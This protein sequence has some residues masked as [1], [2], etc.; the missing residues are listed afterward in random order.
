MFAKSDIRKITIA[1]EKSFYSEVYL[2]LGK[3]GIVHLSRFHERDSVADTGLQH[4]E[5]RT[6][7]ILSG[8]EYA[9]NA[10][11][12]EPE[13]ADVSAQIFD[14]SRDAA[15]VSETKKTIERVVRL[16]KRIR[17]ESDAIAEQVEYMDA[18]NRMGIEPAM[19]E[20][21]RLVNTVFGTVDKTAWDAASSERFMI[22]G[23]G[24]YVFGIALPADFPGMIQF[25]KNYGLIDKSHDVR[26]VS[27]EYLKKR[28]DVLERRI[29]ILDGY[30]HR[31]KEE[32]EQALKRLHSA[33]LAYEKML[34]AMRMSIFSFRAMFVS[35]WMDIKD[36][37][38]LVGI[39]Q[40]ICGNRFVFSERKDPDAPVRL[41]N[42]RLLKPF[43]LLVKTMGMPSNNEIDPTP[44][45]AVTF[46]VMFGLMFG[47]LGQGSVL[48]IGG[49]ILRKFGKKRLRDELAQAGG[50][51]IACGCSAALCGILYGSIFS[52]EHIIPALWFHPAAHIM[53]MFS[54]AVLIG[55]VFIMA[56]LCVNIINSFLNADYT[57]ALL[58]KR[59]LAVLVLYAAVVFLTICYQRT[60]QL[61][62]PWE[63]SVFIILPLMLFSLKGVLGSALFKKAKPQSIS[64]YIIETFLEI[65]EIA[66]S[67]FANTISFIRM[68]AFALSHAGLSIATYTLAGMADPG[69]KSAG[70][71]SIIVI[72]N[73][74]I[75][76]LEGLICVIQS[77][78]LEYYEFFSKFFK[79]NGVVFTPFTLKA[80]ATEV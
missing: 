58:E 62:T 78:R 52:S 2:A 20:Q 70:A 74:F 32:S 19:I 75:I 64:K 56:G 57:E 34:T 37:E 51:L 8:V 49:L 50:I 17:E 39:L 7:E 76:C 14:A 24:Q 38:R 16:R 79:G 31:L 80:K 69:M 27:M 68:G 1:F 28:A 29:E 59:G 23:V 15:F 6:R 5:A 40:G 61:P 43:E 10:L 44:L 35:G 47:D 21:S 25:L 3:A 36:K 60:G 45:T 9:L 41:M 63:I 4:E 77:M 26:P 65:L 18:L 71:V 33:Y 12:I 73:I 42:I 53:Q 54:T 66:L 46:V 55:V 22:T 72:G 30:I 67:L 13:E 48:I 11:L